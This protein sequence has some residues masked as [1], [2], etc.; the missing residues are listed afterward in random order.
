MQTLA[1]KYRPKSFD[2]VVEQ[3]A[4]KEILREQLRSKTYKNSYLFTGGAGTGK[5]T[6]ARIFANELNEGKGQPIEIDAASNNGVENVRSII[7]QAKFKS[8]DGAHKVY[9]IDECHMLSTGAWNAML[10]LLEE[11]P[12]QTI[13]IMCTT[14][15][16]KIPA[17]ILSRVQRFDFQRLTYESIVDRLTKI[18][19]QERQL[20]FDKLNEEDPTEHASMTADSAGYY[21]WDPNALGYIAKLADGG[22]RDAITLL[23]KCLSYSY[24]IALSNV[25]AALGVADYQTMI[26]LTNAVYERQAAEAVEIIEQI[27]R[28]GVDLKQFVKNYLQF[29]LDTKKYQMYRSFEYLSM[30]PVEDLQTWLDQFNDAAGFLN[31]ALQELI[32]LQE[33]IKWET[34]PKALIEASFIYYCEVL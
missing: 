30:P 27:H 7:D 25:V 2:D 21:D 10:K 18:M 19:Q 15:P 22:M 29:I 24:E 1:V 13:F 28:S 9:I 8:L 5:T 14:D 23:D 3:T 6:C 11:P 32:K 17:T 4:V 16:Q 20:A 33:M 31:N 34:A 26:K 12:A